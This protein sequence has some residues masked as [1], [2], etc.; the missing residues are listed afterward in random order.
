MFKVA[1][2]VIFSVSIR[3]SKCKCKKERELNISMHKF[4]GQIISLSLFQMEI[5]DESV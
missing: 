3:K 4:L 5:L 1:K 2:I